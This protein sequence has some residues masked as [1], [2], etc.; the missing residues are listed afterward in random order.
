MIEGGGLGVFSP[1]EVGPVELQGPN[2]VIDVLVED[3]IGGGGGGEEVPLLLPG[4]SRGNGGRADQRPL[5]SLIPENRRAS[6]TCG[7]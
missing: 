6:T 4:S 5:R 7:A 3:E 1:E 2:G